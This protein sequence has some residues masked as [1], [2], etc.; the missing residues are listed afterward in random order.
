MSFTIKFENGSFGTIHYFANGSKSFPKERI[1]VFCDG[2]ILQLDNFQSLR[3]YDWP[4]FRKMS[5]WKQDKGHR[6]SIAKFLDAVRN[7][8]RAPRYHLKRS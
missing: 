7:Q 1:E 2:K 6:E 4:G 5:L 3:G 8:G